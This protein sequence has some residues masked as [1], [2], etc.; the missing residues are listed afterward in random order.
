MKPNIYHILDLCIEEGIKRALNSTESVELSERAKNEVTYKL[1][2]SIWE[3]VDLY[4]TFT[5]NDN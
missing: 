2:T 3:Q 4:F 1:H 5:D